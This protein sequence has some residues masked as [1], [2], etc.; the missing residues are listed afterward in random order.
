LL[1]R[2]ELLQ[3]SE[4]AQPQLF[5]FSSKA[6]LICHPERSAAKSKDLRLFFG[7]EAADPGDMKKRM[8]QQHGLWMEIDKDQKTEYRFE[9]FAGKKR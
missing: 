1:K 9:T 6:F 7:W 2:N 8:L 5:G 3:R 4:I